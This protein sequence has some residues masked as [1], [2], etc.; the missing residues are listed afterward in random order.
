M[1]DL[2]SIRNAS[3]SLTPTGY[4]PEE[5]DQFLV[6][7]AGSDPAS[8]DLA[9]LRNASF[10][11]TPTGYNPE[12]VDEFLGSIADQ[13]AAAPAPRSEQVELESFA[14]EAHEADEQHQ[15][16]PVAEHEAGW[17]DHEAHDDVPAPEAE[18]VAERVDA[19]EHFVAEERHEQDHVAAE[20]QHVDAEQQPEFEPVA[21]ESHDAEPAQDEAPV[22]EHDQDDH[23]EHHDGHEH[24]DQSFPVTAVH[25]HEPET[26]PVAEDEHAHDLVQAHEPIGEAPAAQLPEPVLAARTPAE[27]NRLSETVEGAIDAL[28]GFVANELRAV[29]EAS[30]LEVDDIHTERRRLIDEAAEAGR[31]HIDDARSHAER[32]VAEAR[33][34]GDDLRASLE[35]ELE[36][37]R[38]RFEQALAERDAN[39]QEHIAEVLNEAEARRREADELLATAA[40]AQAAMLASFEQARTS[41]IQA[42]ERTRVAPPVQIVSSG[43]EDVDE[44]D[45]TAAA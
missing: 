30:A 34:E 3:F 26:E 10:S 5:V 13:L 41:L 16:E 9:H 23:D 36:S 7:L 6:E 38:R 32:I 20:E 39:A 40:D 24:D 31:R 44:H 28:E 42:A 35:Q 37:E 14:D 33:R 2:A 19:E 11:L 15:P 43:D 45:A 4:S 8:V 1:M 21:E 12:E 25:W 18:V 22:V 17:A 27:V 29:R